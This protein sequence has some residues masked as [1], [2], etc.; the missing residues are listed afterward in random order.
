MTII[1]FCTT[2]SKVIGPHLLIFVQKVSTVICLHG[3]HKPLEHAP[4]PHSWCLYSPHLLAMGCNSLHSDDGGVSPW[5][6]ATAIQNHLA[7]S[8]PYL[9]PKGIVGFNHL[10]PLH[11]QQLISSELS[12]QEDT[13]GNGASENV[14]TENLHFKWRWTCKKYRNKAEMKANKKTTL[15]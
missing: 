3:V 15:L 4:W 10:P 8:P 6:R 1:S 2:S 7:L 12:N 14:F 11:Y 5:P 13:Q 9:S